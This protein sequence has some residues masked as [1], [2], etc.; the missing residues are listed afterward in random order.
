MTL[1]N[2]R[3]NYSITKC[4]VGTREDKCVLDLLLDI[5]GLHR[6]PTNILESPGMDRVTND[7]LSGTR[8]FQ[9]RYNH[10]KCSRKKNP[11]AFK[12]V[13]NAFIFIAV[14]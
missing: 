4:K 12:K 1:N 3:N 14:R 7:H 6:K 10:L 2:I 11:L 13:G 9:I 5:N 8:N